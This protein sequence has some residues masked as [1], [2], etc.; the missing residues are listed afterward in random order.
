MADFG[1]AH[2]CKNYFTTLAT[3]TATG[4]HL[5]PARYASPEQF[6]K[7]KNIDY[8]TDIYS[9]GKV[10][11]FLV[12]GKIYADRYKDI[13]NYELNKIILKMIE[14]LPEDRYQCLQDV[15]TNL[16]QIKRKLETGK[17]VKKNLKIQNIKNRNI[18][19]GLWKDPSDGNNL[20]LKQFED[21]IVGIYDFNGKREK[22]GYYKGYLNGR[23]F[24]TIGGGLMIVMK[25]AESLS[26]LKMAR[27]YMENGGTKIILKK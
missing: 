23:V 5:M 14:E 3:L 18:L 16:E 21:V 27:V 6:E 1:I 17:F 26:Y 9:L 13:K 10:F 19:T 20:Y 11:Y 22:I 12:K 8:R 7:E 2:L 15:I 4:Q 24:D 25:E